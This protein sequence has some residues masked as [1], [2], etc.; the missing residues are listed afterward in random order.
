MITIDIEETGKNI[1][2][3]R[4]K[5]NI[6]VK[7][8]AKVFG[9]ASG[10]PIYKWQHGESLPTLDNLVILADLLNVKLDD[11]IVIKRAA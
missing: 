4:K 6:S 2:A 11:L 7:E 8:M 3:L 9:F 5:A 1:E 10:Y